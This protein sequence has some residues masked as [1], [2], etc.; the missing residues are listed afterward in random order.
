MSYKLGKRLAIKAPGKKK[1]T[2]NEKNRIRSL[3]FLKMTPL[4]KPIRRNCIT[5]E[6]H[7]KWYAITV[8]PNRK[9][10][11][12]R[13]F[14]KVSPPNFPMI[15]EATATSL[16]RK[17]WHTFFHNTATMEFRICRLRYHMHPLDTLFVGK[18][19][20]LPEAS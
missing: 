12:K 20:Q 8:F 18:Y 13:F 15:F 19:Y 5:P 1:M 17:K 10:R 3:L 16:C 14:A 2:K 7:F 11:T 4:L 6:L 9:G